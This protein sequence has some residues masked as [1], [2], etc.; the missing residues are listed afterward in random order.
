MQLPQVQNNS[1]YTYVSDGIF[2]SKIEI[3]SVVDESNY[4]DM[5][6]SGKNGDLKLLINY[7]KSGD[8]ETKKCYLFGNFKGKWDKVQGK[9]VSKEKEWD[10]S[11]RNLVLLALTNLLGQSPDT[12]DNNWHITPQAMNKLKGKKCWLFKYFAGMTDDN[13]ENQQTFSVFPIEATIAEMTEKFEG[14]K[15][16]GI[17]KKWQSYDNRTGNVKHDTSPN[18]GNTEDTKDKDLPF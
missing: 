11:S 2:L 18:S 4:P 13:K 8:A 17:M 6:Y 7:L 10:V 15:L 9:F 12:L 1:S 14:L 5:P 3:V 16:D